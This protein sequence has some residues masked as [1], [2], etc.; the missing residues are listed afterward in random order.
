MYRWRRQ[1]NEHYIIPF[2]Q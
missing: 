2:T 1:I